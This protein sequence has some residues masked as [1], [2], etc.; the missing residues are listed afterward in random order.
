ME[1]RARFV[2]V[3]VAVGYVMWMKV[4]SIYRYLV[5]VEMLV[6]LVVFVLLTFVAGEQDGRKIARPLIGAMMVLGVLGS[7]RTWGHEGWTDPVYQVQMPPITAPERTTIVVYSE[8]SGRGW[9]VPF[10]PRQVAFAS[11]DGS[12]PGSAAYDQRI[13]DMVVS[14]GGEGI[15]LIDGS[16]DG[17]ATS[18]AKMEKIVRT[19]DFTR[20]ARGCADLKWTVNRLHL[21][22]SVEGIPNEAEKCRLTER[23]DDARRAELVG[24]RS[25]NQTVQAFA[26]IG[27]A[28]DPQTCKPYQASIGTGIVAYRLCNR[29]PRSAPFSSPT[30]PASSA[31][32]RPS[33]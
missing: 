28:L 19:L 2:V 16:D 5:P 8:T 31:R 4:F 7:L 10:F 11:L 30:E 20:S 23:A 1:S 22:A 29:R 3:F 13:R 32:T 17:R 12:F 21:H 15:A 6:P 24:L 14:R 26:R 9:M 25:L 33:S 27:L 18:A